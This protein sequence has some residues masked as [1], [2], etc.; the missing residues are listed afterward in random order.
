MDRI[1]NGWPESDMSDSGQPLAILPFITNTL[2]H[3]DPLI[4]ILALFVFTNI[5]LYNPYIDIDH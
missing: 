2:A 1:A 3:Y 4:E 5:R